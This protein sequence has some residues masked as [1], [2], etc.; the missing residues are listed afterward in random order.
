MDRLIGWRK[1]IEVLAGAILSVVAL[2]SPFVVANKDVILT[3][4]AVGAPALLAIGG[5]IANVIIAWIHKKPIVI[6]E[7]PILPTEV[8]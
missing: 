2:Y 5:L 8:K 6:P 1:V 3:A 7:P 4:I